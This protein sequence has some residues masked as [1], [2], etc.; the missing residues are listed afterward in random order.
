MRIAIDQTTDSP[1]TGVRSRGCFRSSI[2]TDGVARSMLAGA[3]QQGRLCFQGHLDIRQT[4]G[5]R[6][7]ERCAH[8]LRHDWRVTFPPIVERRLE[9][10]SRRASDH[11]DHQRKVAQASPHVGSDPYFPGG[12]SGRCNSI[13]AEL[14]PDRMCVQG[15]NRRSALRRYDHRK[16]LSR[17]RRF[18]AP[19]LLMAGLDESDTM[20]L[21]G[22]HRLEIMQNSAPL[23][24][25]GYPTKAS[26][27]IAPSASY[28]LARLFGM[29]ARSSVKP[30][31]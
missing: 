3:H 26:L 27:Q 20:Q 7:I 14:C 29:L 18:L 30:L 9:L 12:R 6:G 25:S 13:F 19:T 1:T 4:L 24:R 17:F 15:V 10:R 22:M 5:R 11:K 21:R 2:R 31:I 8:D 28:A 16:R 23:T